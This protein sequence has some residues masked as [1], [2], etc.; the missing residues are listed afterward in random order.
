MRFGDV[1]KSLSITMSSE[2]LQDSLQKTVEQ[3][4]KSQKEQAKSIVS[5]KDLMARKTE[6]EAVLQELEFIKDPE[7]AKV[8][9]LLGPTLISQTLDEAK[10][11]VKKRM[12]F[13]DKEI[14]RIDDFIEENE[15][16]QDKFRE[17]LQK[18]QT[19]MQKLNQK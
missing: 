4:Q 15:Q 5:R 1:R 9:K 2:K 16:K 13:M 8:F 3:L 18:V 10:N 12:E 14:K 19:Q 7:N 11:N 6:S 17:E